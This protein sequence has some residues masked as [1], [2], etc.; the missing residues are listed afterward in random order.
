MKNIN[1]DPDADAVS[2]KL[3]SAKSHMTAEITEHILLDLDSNNNPIGLEI[4]DASEE[5]S[6][7]FGRIVS[8]N[9]I[10]QILCNFEQEP[11][12]QY[13]IQFNSPVKKEHASIIIPLYKSPIIS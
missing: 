4:L 5:I 11:N 8:K 9:E 1:Y 12:N 6:K 10:K 3:R 2:L 13:R 7:A